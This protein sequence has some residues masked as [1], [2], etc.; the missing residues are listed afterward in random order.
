MGEVGLKMLKWGGLFVVSGSGKTTC[1]EILQ[2]HTGAT[3]LHYTTRVEHGRFKILKSSHS[4]TTIQFCL[5]TLYS[6]IL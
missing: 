2:Q 5:L 6:D 4:H 3:T 1:F